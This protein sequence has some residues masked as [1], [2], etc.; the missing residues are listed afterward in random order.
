MTAQREGKEKNASPHR[1]RSPQAKR[2][3][4]PKRAASRPSKGTRSRRSRSRVRSYRASTF[5]PVPDEELSAMS[6]EKLKQL[7]KEYE[8]LLTESSELTVACEAEMQTMDELE[9]KVK[10]LE[11]ELKPYQEHALQ[12]QEHRKFEDIVGYQFS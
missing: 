3:S 12:K 1:R 10:A 4:A 7:V 6:M 5:T 2:K 9:A 11:A 8:E